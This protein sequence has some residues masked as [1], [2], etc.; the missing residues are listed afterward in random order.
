[1]DLDNNKLYFS[2]NG[3]FQNSG[4][5]TSGATGTGAIA[6]AANKTYF[7]VVGDS[8]PH[9]ITNEM[10]FGSPPFAISSGNTDG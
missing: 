1:M 9:A 10:N 5:P 6:I 3:T 2:V 8:T 7:F 4:D